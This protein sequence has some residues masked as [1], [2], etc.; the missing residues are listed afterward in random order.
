MTPA[1]EQYLAWL[2]SLGCE[3]KNSVVIDMGWP[4]PASL[5]EAARREGRSIRNP[6]HRMAFVQMRAM[7]LRDAAGLPPAV[8]YEDL[9]SLRELFQA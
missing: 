6:T 9:E 3:V 8:T 5:V 4:V 1:V 2:K 7:A